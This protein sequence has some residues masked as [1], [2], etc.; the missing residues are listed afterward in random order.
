MTD[1]RYKIK[2]LNDILTIIKDYPE[3]ADEIIEDTNKF[4]K[5]RKKFI[6]ASELLEALGANIS[7]KPEFVFIPD[8]KGEVT[9][10]LE[11]SIT[12]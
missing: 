9:N 6:G 5:Q 8:G 3:Y 1:G 11:I 4:L 2:T 12:K 10:K 7:A